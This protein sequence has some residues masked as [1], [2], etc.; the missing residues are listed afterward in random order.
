MTLGQIGG[1]CGDLVGDHAVLDVLAVRQPEVLLGGDVAQHRGAGLG[2]DCSTDR[3]GDVVVA[4]GDVG[5]QRAQRVEGCL[6]AELLFQTHVLDDLVHRDVAGALDH[7]LHAMGFGDL[8]QLAEGAQFGELRLVVGVG[9]R[10]RPQPVT[11]RERHVVAGE[12]LAQLPEVR[13]QE[14]LGVMRQAPGSHDRAAP[15]DDAGDPLD[16]ERD[17]AQQH[18]GVHS[19]VVHALLALLVTVSR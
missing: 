5:G 8:G 17:V 18:A 11:Q 3:T 12:D 16:R 4:G 2:D 10:S 13:V 15:A 19:H 6:L 14:R 9:D 7:H 1:M